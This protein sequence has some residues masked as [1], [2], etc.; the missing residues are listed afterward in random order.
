MSRHIHIIIVVVMTDISCEW[1][2]LCLLVDG[3]IVNNRIVVVVVVIVIGWGGCVC[4]EEIN[5]IGSTAVGKV[6]IDW[7]R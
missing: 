2:W 7:C 4:E 6:V 5:A 3:L 1:R